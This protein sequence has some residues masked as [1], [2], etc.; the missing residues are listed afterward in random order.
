M[1]Y[2]AAQ[3]REKRKREREAA[4]AG[5]LDAV[6]RREAERA[7]LDELRTPMDNLLRMRQHRARVWPQEQLQREQKQQQREQKQLQSKQLPERR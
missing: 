7:R 4:E 1:P 3:Q 2:T 5:D 6:R